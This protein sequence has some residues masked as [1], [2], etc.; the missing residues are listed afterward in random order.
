M[1]DTW[2]GLRACATIVQFAIVGKCDRLARVDEIDRV[3]IRAAGL[4][5]L[6]CKVLFGDGV[7][8]VGRRAPIAC[9]NLLAQ[10]GALQRPACFVLLNCR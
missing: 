6:D 10:H 8:P 3:L 7:R 9:V 5:R 2:I 4:E 1:A